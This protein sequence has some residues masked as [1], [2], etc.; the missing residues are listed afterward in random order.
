VK[1]LGLALLLYCAVSLVT[2]HGKTYGGKLLLFFDMFWCAIIW[3]DT[4]I[5]ISSMVGL[6]IRRPNPGWWARGL[7]ATLNWIETDHCEL[8]IKNDLLRAQAAQLILEG[9]E[10]A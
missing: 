4:G 10:Q 1:W 8:A 7:H 6:E 5:T 9:K 2:G 3:R